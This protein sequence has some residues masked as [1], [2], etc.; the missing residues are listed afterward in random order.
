MKLNYSREQLEK[1]AHDIRVD[2]VESLHCAGSGHPG[3][4]LS[5]AEML[6]VLY[7]HEMNAGP[8][9]LEDGDRDRFVLSKG[10]AA[11]AY[12]AALAERGYFSRERLKT[13]RQ[14]DSFLQGHPDRKK[15]PGVDMST[16]SLGQ[17]IS[18]AAGMACYGKKEGKNFRVYCIIGDG[19]MQEGEVWEALMAS[20]HFKLS[21]FTVLLD[22]NGLQI[23]GCVQEVM[24]I[25]PIREKVEA[26]GWQVLE[27]DGHDVEDLMRV[28]EEGRRNTETPTFI[29]CETVKGKGV[30]FMENQAG[31]HGAPISDE[32]YEQAMKDLDAQ[33]NV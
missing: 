25:H 27:A 32:Q 19:E 4:S 31:W 11:P 28:L 12:Y 1:T 33:F 2:I 16:G 29:I 18:A 9:S 23:D 20:A 5:I 26:F 21:N 30:S 3:G 13:L 10:H 6:S 8:E 14:I 15:V 22:R 7:F 17:G 24:S